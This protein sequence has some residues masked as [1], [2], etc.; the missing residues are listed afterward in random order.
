MMAEQ[1]KNRFLQNKT[2]QKCYPT[3]YIWYPQVSAHEL[4]GYA[5]TA[6]VSKYSHWYFDAGCD[7]VVMQSEWK[8]INSLLY[9]EIAEGKNDKNTGRNSGMTIA[10]RLKRPRSRSFVLR[11]AMDNVKNDFGQK[12]VKHKN[13]KRDTRKGL[14]VNF[15]ENLSEIS[16]LIY[17]R[18]FYGI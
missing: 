7:G 2:K 9:G 18:I 3:P 16:D 4:R 5:W 11:K 8:T 17:N 13:P 10:P 1:S 15:L 14:E 12:R 6:S